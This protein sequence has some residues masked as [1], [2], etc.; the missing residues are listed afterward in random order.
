M[1]DTLKELSNDVKA[2]N[3]SIV[4]SEQQHIQHQKIS[5]ENRIELQGHDRRI[6]FTER[7]MER[8]AGSIAIV[9]WIIGISSSAVVMAIGW[10]LSL[11]LQTQAI[12]AVNQSKH[13]TIE[14]RLQQLETRRDGP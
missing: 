8:Q 2:L 12:V 7:Q 3:R 4:Q 11:V 14:A 13:P 6:A 5:D 10:L 1:H 9:K